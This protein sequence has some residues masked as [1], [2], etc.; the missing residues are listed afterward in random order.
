MTAAASAQDYKEAISLEVLPM[1]GY[2]SVEAFFDME[3][4]FEA[5]GTDYLDENNVCYY[6]E[7]GELIVGRDGFTANNGYWY[8]MDGVVAPYGDTSFYAEYNEGCDWIDF[9]QMPGAFEGGEELAFKFYFTNEGKIAELDIDVKILVP[10]KIQADKV[11][12]ASALVELEEGGVYEGVPVEVDYAAIAEALGCS[13]AETTVVGYKPNGDITDVYTA[14]NGFWYNYEGQIS[15]YADG[16][17][18]AELWAGEDADDMIHVGQ[19]PDRLE[20]GDEVTVAFCLM[21]EG[22]LAE[23]NITVKIKAAAV[24]AGDIV[25]TENVS[26]TMEADNGYTPVPVVVNE[27]AISAAIGCPIADSMFVSYKDGELTKRY[28]GDGLM[29]W[30]DK[31]GNI[32]SWGENASIYVGF[33]EAELVVAQMPNTFANG[34]KVTVVFGFLNEDKVAVVNLTYEVPGEGWTAVEAVEATGVKTVYNLQGMK[35]NA[36]QL[37]AGLYIINGKKVMVK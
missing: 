31:D 17:V 32:G 28:T 15:A 34:G 33:N 35:M 20:G 1:Q 5:L 14:G 6:N 36:E 7:E 18:F 26:M 12:A 16:S 2:A 9:G 25:Y 23:V 22:K 29:F 30:Y 13:I 37:P 19:Y 8:T 21:H 4:V 11:F 10:E 27:E 24:L 3:A